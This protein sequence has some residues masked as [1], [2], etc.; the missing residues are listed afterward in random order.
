MVVPQSHQPPFHN[1][2]ESHTQSRQ[3]SGESDVD[4]AEDADGGGDG[5]DEDTDGG[6]D[7]NAEGVPNSKPQ[8][9]GRVLL[10]SANDGNVESVPN[11]DPRQGFAGKH[12]LSHSSSSSDEGL[13]DAEPNPPRRERPNH[14]LRTSKCRCAKVCRDAVK[15]LAQDRKPMSIDLSGLDSSESGI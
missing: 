14:A 7:G 1:T 2:D 15:T 4:G 11:S 5:N 3:C 10:V 9:Q 12:Q 8:I 13:T 6:I